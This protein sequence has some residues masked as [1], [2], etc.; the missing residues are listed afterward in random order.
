V[1]LLAPP[2]NREELLRRERAEWEKQE[3]TENRESDSKQLLRNAAPMIRGHPM[4]MRPSTF[5]CFEVAVVAAGVAYL[6]YRYRRG[7]KQQA[8]A[9]LGTRSS[10][11]SSADSDGDR[12]E[13]LVENYNSMVN[14]NIKGGVK[15]LM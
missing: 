6:A 9:L 12:Q 11:S 1:D 15:V 4:S 13:W 5:R 2:S 8:E 14:S 3:N 7:R 10:S